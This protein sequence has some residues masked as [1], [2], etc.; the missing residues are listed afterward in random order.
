M[1]ERHLR[2]NRRVQLKYLL[3]GICMINIIKNAV[4]DF[5]KN[6]K[7]VNCVLQWT[8]QGQN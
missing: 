1:F 3:Q 7:I 5:K 8:A 2:Q 4:L 6:E